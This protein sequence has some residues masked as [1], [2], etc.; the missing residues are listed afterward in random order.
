MRALSPP[1]TALTPDLAEA[2]QAFLQR[3]QSDL[4]ALL[5]ELV[6]AESPSTEPATQPR[7][8]GLLADRLDALGFAVRHLPGRTSGG[9]LYARPAQR[10]RGA[11]VQLL[12]GHADTVW[13]V[14]TLERMP[15]AV[16]AGHAR[17]PGVYDMKAG[18]VQIVAALDALDGLGLAPPATPVVFVNTD[19]EIGSAESGRWIAWLAQAAARAFVLEPAL[20]PEG[21]LKTA[22]KGVGKFHVV[23]RGRGSHAGLAPEEGASAILELSHVVQRLHAL[24]DLAAGISVNVGMIEGGQRPNVVAPEARAIVDVR[25]PT[26]EAARRVEA[27]I[28]AI[29]ATTPGATVEFTG[30]IGRPPLERTPRN[31]RL[32]AQAQEAARCLGLDLTEGTAGGGSD[33]NTTSL[34][35]ATLDGLGAVGDGAHADHE[36]AEVDRI[37]ERAALLALLLVAPLDDDDGAAPP[38]ADGV[39]ASDRSPPH[40]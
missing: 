38:A 12:L 34:F 26:A 4:V 29:E 10:E 9:H 7:V 32:W 28:L 33:G 13:P 1:P 20:G 39:M 6:E 19:E 5:R 23:V 22:R 17:G 21:R 11:P 14:G 36:F 40:R 2:V 8:L 37:A 30:G 15:F 31:R 16:R 18:L 3:R 35:T 25:V 24:S 27:E